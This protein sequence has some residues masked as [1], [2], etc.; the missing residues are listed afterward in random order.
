MG[1]VV[2]ADIFFLHDRGKYN[3]LYFATYFGSLVVLHLQFDK[4]HPRADMIQVGATVAGPMADHL[5]WRV[6]FWLN[7]GVLGL[8]VLMLLFL[9]PETKW[10]RSHTLR[11]GTP[12]L[13]ELPPAVDN[14][15]LSHTK[16][17]AEED[18]IHSETPQNEARLRESVVGRGSPSKSQFRFLQLKDQHTTLLNELW[19]P[20]RLFAYPIVHFASFV[21]SWS[22][23]LFLTVN[24][25]QAQ[26]FAA[27]PYSYSS[28]TIGMCFC[29][30]SDLTQKDS[31]SSSFL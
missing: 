28:Q 17:T 22:A 23:S 19:M 7:V 1:P 8:S 27:P 2:I 18:S 10:H 3:A 25:T 9:F 12:S 5:G 11:N 13:S 6:F 29:F 14:K 4:I 24:L 31:R 15:F 26:N 21:V 16:E 30:T 20:W